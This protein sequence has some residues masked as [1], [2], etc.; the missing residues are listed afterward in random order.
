[1]LFFINQSIKLLLLV[2]LVVLIIIA[3]IIMMIIV[4]MCS[5][6]ATPSIVS[7]FDVFNLLLKIGQTIHFPTAN[8]NPAHSAF[9]VVH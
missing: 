8:T 9:I 3:T 7:Y 1:M 2:V 4:I 6:H 5:L